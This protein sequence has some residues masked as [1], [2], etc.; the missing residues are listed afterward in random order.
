LER[1]TGEEVFFAVAR[2]P[3][4]KF[5]LESARHV[6]PECAQVNADRLALLR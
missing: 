4:G 5:R 3:K 6:L 2:W 1:L